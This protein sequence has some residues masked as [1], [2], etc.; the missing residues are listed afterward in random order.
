MNI[1]LKIHWK[2]KK[3]SAPDHEDQGRLRFATLSDY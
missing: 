3:E 1:S 2:L